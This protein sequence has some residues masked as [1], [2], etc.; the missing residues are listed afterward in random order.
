MTTLGKTAGIPIEEY[1]AAE[2]ISHSKL[3]VFRQRPALFKKRFIDKSV[4]RESTAAF[5]IG[6]AL[7]CAVLEPM[8][9]A[10]RY[11]T[12]PE[13]I[14]RRTSAG[15]VA[16]SAFCAENEGKTILDS[17][18]FELVRNM[19]LA[20]N[21]NPNASSLLSFGQAEMTWRARTPSIP[22]HLQCRTDWFN[23]AG[24]DLSGGR[25][26]ALDIKTVESLDAAAFRSFEK[27]FVNFG[28]H[29]QC[30]F[31]LPLMQDCGVTVRDFFFIA[32]EKCEPFGVAIYKPTDEA[33]EAGLN[34]S[35]ADLRRLAECY[36]EDR[37]P[38][39]PLEVQE[40]GLPAW[41]RS[42]EDAA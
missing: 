34:E 14:D 26:Y 23:Q 12:R 9:Y 13:G 10:S 1:H 27:A 21:A 8:N 4:E 42:K 2:S 25:P 31:Y 37:W 41:Y 39:M 3:E 30:G 11:A 22:H 5:A 29:R 38:N 28:Y 15:K 6:S 40:I 35:V 16:F 17:D 24:G 36:R 32:V 19:A 7:H 33:I 18:E 20:I